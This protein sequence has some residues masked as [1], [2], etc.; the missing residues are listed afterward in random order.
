MSAFPA[1]KSD[2]VAWKKTTGTK[3]DGSHLHGTVTLQK[4]GP[5]WWV[6]VYPSSGG[7]IV[8]T[9]EKLSDAKKWATGRLSSLEA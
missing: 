8:A 9:F 6:A 3:I 4:H 7:K 5:L 1:R 2:K